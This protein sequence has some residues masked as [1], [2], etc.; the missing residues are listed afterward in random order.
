MS[1]RKDRLISRI[2]RAT[3]VPKRGVKRFVRALSH[4]DRGSFLKRI[5]TFIAR[6]GQIAL[7]PVEVH[8]ML[9]LG[10]AHDTA[11]AYGKKTFNLPTT[12]SRKDIAAAVRA[13]RPS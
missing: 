11:E 10:N 1:T 9:V 3:K 12:A 5:D 8:R 7:H 2:S 13:A 6:D 4:R